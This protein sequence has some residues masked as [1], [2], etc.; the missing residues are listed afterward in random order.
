MLLRELGA[1]LLVLVAILVLGN[2]WFGLV[3]WALSRLRR[4]VFRHQEPSGWHTLPEEE[5]D[6]LP[7]P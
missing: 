3:E 7:P 2:L 6:D 1:C 5:E 4:L